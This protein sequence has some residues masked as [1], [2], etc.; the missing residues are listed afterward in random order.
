MSPRTVLRA[1]VA[2]LLAGAAAAGAQPGAPARSLE[3]RFRA[4]DRDGDGKLTRDEARAGMPAVHRLFGRLD[5]AGQGYLTLE[6]LQQLAAR[7]GARR[8]GG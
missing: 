1:A 3:E 8:G 4:A 2:A 6:Q 7:R 5:G